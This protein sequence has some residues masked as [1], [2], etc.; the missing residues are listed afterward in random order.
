MLACAV[1][2]FPQRQIKILSIGKI[3]LELRPAPGRP[4]AATAGPA[5]R[6]RARPATREKTMARIKTSVVPFV[7]TATGTG[8]AQQLIAAGDAGHQF[9]AD[10][11]PAFGGQDA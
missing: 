4:R 7:V 10:A 8:T 1:P 2:V 3:G 5:H 11:Y 6:E 9:A